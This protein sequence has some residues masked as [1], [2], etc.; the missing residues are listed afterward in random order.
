MDWLPAFVVAVVIYWGLGQA[1]A[2]MAGDP[3]GGVG[4]GSGGRY[5]DAQTDVP[6]LLFSGEVDGVGT[7]LQ[8]YENGE[9]AVATRLRGQSCRE[10]LISIDY[11]S[12]SMRRK[13]MTGRGLAA[14][15]TG[16]LSLAASNNRGVVYLTLVGDTSGVHT[17]TTRNPDG[18]VL[19]NL[20]A[21]KAVG[22]GVIA[23]TGASTNVPVATEADLVTQIQAL[24]SM[25]EQGVLSGEEFAAAKARLLG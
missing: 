13:S 2:W 8:I 25:H 3:G 18:F 17:F 21:A 23:R 7:E 12:D 14:M 6:D 15:T 1:R 9:F 10:R 22:D 11:D 24:L 20:R 16:G 19:D 5:G 4:G